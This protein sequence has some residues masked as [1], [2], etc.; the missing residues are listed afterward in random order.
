MAIECDHAAW[1]YAWKCYELA[2]RRASVTSV[3]PAKLSK[4]NNEYGSKSGNRGYRSNTRYAE[5]TAR[6]GRRLFMSK[7]FKTWLGAVFV[8]VM[9][10]ALASLLVRPGFA[11]I[12]TSDVLQGLL[13]LSATLCFLPGVLHTRGRTRLFWSL[14]LLGMAFW[15]TYQLMWIYFEVYLRK[16]VPN[17]FAGDVILFL[18]IVPMIAALALQPHVEQDD[19][20]TRLGSLDFAL[21]LIWWIYLYLYAV[22]PWQYVTRDETIYEHNLN[23]LYLTEK[24]VLLGGLLWVWSRCH[25]SWRK[26]YAHWFGASLTYAGFSYLANWAIERNVYYTGSFYD[27]PLAGSMAWVTAVGLVAYSVNPQQEPARN[28]VTHGVWV[29]RLGMIAVFSLPLFAARSLFDSGIP[30]RLRTFRLVVTLA[31]MLVMGVLVFLKQHLLDHELV[32]LL[33]SSQDSFEN[34]QKLQVQLVQSEKMA[35]LGQLVGGAA[36]ELN[37]PLTAMLGYSDLLAGTSLN[38]Q[39]RILSEKMTHQ[40][41]RTKTLVS[42]LLN[43]ARQSPSKKIPIDVNGLLRT[44][45]KLAQPQFQAHNLRVQM[46]LADHAALVLGD[47]NQLLQVCLHVTNNATQALSG[48][49]AVL[50][51]ST[52]TQGNFAVMEFSSLGDGADA[53][54]IFDPYRSANAIHGPKS[55]GL[56]TCYGIIQDHGGRIMCQNRPNSGAIFRIELPLATAGSSLPDSSTSLQKINTALTIGPTGH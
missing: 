48:K 55:I 38:D 6:I 14:T 31:T 15:F 46:N 12:A 18:H 47:S 21:L 19:R 7:P 35:S 39:Q 40:I 41:R 10:Q 30:P 16:D 52:D 44:A 13:L 24:M 42:S 26:V 32:Q 22:I 53:D 36:H 29:A 17:P 20:T 25:G 49:G 27:V 4:T 9:L 56:N 5:M 51:V 2:P 1:E 33:R 37:N 45:V 28:S 54:Q 3:S 23:A 50:G 11:L 8:L 43:F 34:L